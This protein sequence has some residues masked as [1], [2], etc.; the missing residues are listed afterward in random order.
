MNKPKTTNRRPT[1]VE[2]LD[3]LV[4]PMTKTAEGLSEQAWDDYDVIR[5]YLFNVDKVQD[6][7]DKI[8][9]PMAT[10]AKEISPA[11]DDYSDLR[12]PMR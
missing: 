6:A 10:D 1:L 3:R 2:R 11:L 12:E 4:K 8:Y 5:R 7:F 9:D